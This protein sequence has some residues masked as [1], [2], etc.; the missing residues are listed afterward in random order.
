MSPLVNA[1]DRGPTFWTML[2]VGT[3]I[4]DASTSSSKNFSAGPT[5]MSGRSATAVHCWVSDSAGLSGFAGVTP[6]L[7]NDTLAIFLF[8]CFG[9]S[10]VRIG[11]AK[12]CIAGFR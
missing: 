8:G 4:S 6:D 10:Q 12:L 9:L 1:S 5:A 7:L 3:L 11:G 2:R